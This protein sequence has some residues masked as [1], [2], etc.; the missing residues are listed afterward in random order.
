MVASQREASEEEQ[1]RPEDTK[2][3]ARARYRPA[4]RDAD[5][6][7]VSVRQ[8]RADLEM[9]QK[10]FVNA[11]GFSCGA[12]RDW[13]QGRT[14]PGY[15]ARTRLYEILRDPERMISSPSGWPRADIGGECYSHPR[16]PNAARSTPGGAY[17]PPER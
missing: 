2:G 10:E 17:H 11:Y 1:G 9:S 14:K 15:C 16:S 5:E 12:V 7:A 4:A 13:E 6:V 8:L 3:P